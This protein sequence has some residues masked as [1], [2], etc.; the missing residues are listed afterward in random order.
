MIL[1]TFSRHRDHLLNSLGF[2]VNCTSVTH[3]A[4]GGEVLITHDLLAR[5]QLQLGEVFPLWALLTTTTIIPPNGSLSTKYCVII[6]M[7]MIKVF[8]VQ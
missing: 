7:M 8:L 3:K 5:G 1:L 2:S 6:I 4:P